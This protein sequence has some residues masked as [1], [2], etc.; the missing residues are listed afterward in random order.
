L[1]EPLANALVQAGA[2]IVVGAHAHVQLGAGFL[3][4]AFVDYGLGNLAFYDTTPPETYSGSLLVT[5][6]GRHI[7]S[8]QWRPALIES[9][10]PVPLA[11]DE[12]TAADTRWAGLR[13]CTDLSAAAAPSLATSATEAE[14][15]PASVVATL[16]GQL[17]DARTGSPG[18]TR[19]AARATKDS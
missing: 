3:G 10:I 8:T 14:L 7:D 5:V 19:R 17:P 9:G 18:T 2:D 1:Q 16:S 6:T 15:P 11:G 12:A 13:S 4:T